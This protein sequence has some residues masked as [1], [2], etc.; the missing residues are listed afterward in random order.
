MTKICEA[1]TEFA[2][3]LSTQDDSI[4]DVASPTMDAEAAA[5]V[6][7]I[8]DAGDFQQFAGRPESRSSARLAGRIPGAQPGRTDARSMKRRRCCLRS[9]PTRM[10][11]L[12]GSNP[13]THF[14]R[15]ISCGWIRRCG[16]RLPVL[17]RRQQSRP[18]EIFGPAPSPP[19]AKGRRSCSVAGPNISTR[20]RWKNCGGSQSRHRSKDLA[21]GDDDLPDRRRCA[22]KR[23]SAGRRSAGPQN[24]VT[25]SARYGSL[26][27]SARH[28]RFSF[29][30]WSSSAAASAARISL[31]APLAS[32]C[33][34]AA[35]RSAAAA[36]R[37]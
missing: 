12:R 26:A 28:C 30:D 13:R 32:P 16:D 34:A 15:P 11:W 1:V 17:S 33:P 9:F 21:R 3:D 29:S 25:K 6:E 7:T 8:P 14:H 4:P 10:A 36:L 2:S 23:R 35:P 31:A 5:A 20:K 18:Y 22:G 37:R 19:V 27:C 24:R